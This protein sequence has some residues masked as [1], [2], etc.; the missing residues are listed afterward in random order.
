MKSELEAFSERTKIEGAN[1]LLDYKQAQRFS[2]AVHELATNAVK[3]GALSASGHVRIAW[4]ITKDGKDTILK[5]RWKEQKGP[6]VLNPTRHGFGTTLLK[7]M[8]T[9]SR[10]DYA[11]DGFGCEL[12]TVLTASESIVEWQAT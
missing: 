3:Y 9:G 7:T 1:I 6:I 4:T 10:F 5:F 2:L 8:F 11:P 12:E